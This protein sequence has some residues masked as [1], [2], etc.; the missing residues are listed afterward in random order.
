MILLHFEGQKLCFGA[1]LDVSGMLH[2]AQKQPQEFTYPGDAFLLQQYP[3]QKKTIIW[4][5]NEPLCPKKG[6]SHPIFLAGKRGLVTCMPL[7]KEKARKGKR[8]ASK[9]SKEKQKKRQGKQKKQAKGGEKKKTNTE[10]ASS[11]EHFG[12]KKVEISFAEPLSR[13]PIIPRCPPVGLCKQHPT[14]ERPGSG[15]APPSWDLK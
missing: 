14:G 12:E 1:F 10:K 13:R 5:R 4:G 15:H 2:R 11:S 3:P 9:K 7:Q 6:V 8:K